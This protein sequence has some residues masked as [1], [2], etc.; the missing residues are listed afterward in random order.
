MK[1]AILLS[2]LLATSAQA[3]DTNQQNFGMR[4]NTQQNQAW[5][6]MVREQN[7]PRIEHSTGNIFGGE[8]FYGNKGYM[9]HSQPNVHGG[10]NFYW[11]Y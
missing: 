7:R 5:N 10:R 6:N 2:T 8:N 4:Q 3:W 11:N 1:Y 9:G